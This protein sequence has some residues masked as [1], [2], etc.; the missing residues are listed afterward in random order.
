MKRS[1]AT[2]DEPAKSA[3]NKRSFGWNGFI[4]PILGKK[5]RRS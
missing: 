5:A 3:R 2:F 1:L 4:K